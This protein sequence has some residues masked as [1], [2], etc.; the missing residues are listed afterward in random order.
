[1]VRNQLFVKKIKKTFSW[2]PVVLF[3]SLGMDIKD[4]KTIKVTKLEKQ[5]LEELASGM[6]AEYNYSDV[7][8]EDIAKGTGLS[9]NVLRGV[10]SSLQ[11]KGLISIDDREGEGYKYKTNMHI[12]Y[13]TFETAGLVEHWIG[14][15][16]FFNPENIV[17]PILLEE[18]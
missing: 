9:H 1:M 14:E 6:Y 8:I 12:W 15:S 7:G 4:I 16:H 17:K 13:L 3:V 5:V 11:K 10:A 18:M 2:S